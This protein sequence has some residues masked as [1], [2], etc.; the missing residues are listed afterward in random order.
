MIYRLVGVFYNQCVILL[1]DT[2]HTGDKMGVIW[3]FF[4][5]SSRTLAAVMYSSAGTPG[6]QGVNIIQTRCYR[7]MF[8]HFV[9]RSYFFILVIF[10]R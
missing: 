8:S 10:L 3:I 9:V 5:Y 6:Q 1:G 7:S 4:F 2:A